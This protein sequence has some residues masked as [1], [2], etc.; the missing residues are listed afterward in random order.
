MEFVPAVE[1][2][3]PPE[4]LSPHEHYFLVKIADRILYTND[5][6]FRACSMTALY[7]PNINLKYELLV[8]DQQ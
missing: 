7:F 8:F 4:I 2:L 5:T 6:Y 3:I 1:S